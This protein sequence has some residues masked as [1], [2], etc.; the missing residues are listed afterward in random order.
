MVR[1][2]ERCVSAHND[3]LNSAAI[4]VVASPN[5]IRDWLTTTIFPASCEQEAKMSWP[6][7]NT[8]VTSDTF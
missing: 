1:N 2:Y 7:K 3:T 6:G 4:R 5:W 8:E